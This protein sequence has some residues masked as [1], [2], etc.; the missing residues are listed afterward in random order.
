MNLR[1][2]KELLSNNDD[3]KNLFLISFS[4]FKRR[5][6]NQLCIFEPTLQHHAFRFFAVFITIIINKLLDSLAGY[7]MINEYR[8]LTPDNFYTLAG[9]LLMLMKSV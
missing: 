4:N 5:K 9:S 6:K 2:E 7:I 1:Y 3:A 8:K